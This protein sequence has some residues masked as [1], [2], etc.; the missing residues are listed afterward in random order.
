MFK[1]QYYFN[2][3]KK[4]GYIPRPEVAAHFDSKKFEEP[5]MMALDE[6]P[7]GHTISPNNV[8]IPW[9]YLTYQDLEV[10]RAIFAPLTATDIFP[11]R[12]QGPWNLRYTEYRFMEHAGFVAQYGDFSHEG[13]VS[14]NP[15]YP[16]LE[17]IMLQTIM[18]VG[19]LEDADYS[20]AGFSIITEKELAMADVLNR[21]ANYIAFFGT[22]GINNWGILTNPFANDAISVV[23]EQLPDGTTT[24]LLSEMTSLGLYNQVRA[25]I[26]ELTRVTMGIVNTRSRVAIVAS[27]QVV[28]GIATAANMYGLLSGDFINRALPNVT[29]VEAPEYGQDINGV[30]EYIQAIALDFRGSP[31]GEIIMNS[32]QRSHG[33]RR[34]LSS[35]E[36]KKS[37]GTFGTRI[38]WP[39]GVAT[40]IASWE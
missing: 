32:R 33:V 23:P 21:A 12:I 30:G 35:I 11:L 4:K 37:M 22:E 6:L 40:M 26:M 10:V 36:E 9:Q 2:E 19:D 34:M 28:A 24:V 8:G 1:G 27:P 20:S 15:S 5:P 31:T 38:K 39:M 17:A 7:Y 29:F 14:I 25:L 13:G 18:K 3:L 16:Q